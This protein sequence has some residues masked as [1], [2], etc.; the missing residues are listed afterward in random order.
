MQRAAQPL[1]AEAKPFALVYFLTH[2]DKEA[3][4]KSFDTFRKDADWEKA[5][6]ASEEKGGG[7]LTVKDGVKS[8]VLVPVEKSP[9][10]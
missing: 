2:K 5:R 10:K 9:I 4:A 1:I 7:S 3:M 6:K 8:L